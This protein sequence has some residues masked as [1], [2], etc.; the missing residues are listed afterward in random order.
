MPAENKVSILWQII[1]VLF[2]PIA[3]IWAFYRIKKLQKFFLYIVLPTIVLMLLI[4]I[5]IVYLSIDAQND[6]QKIDDLPQ[7][8]E[9]YSLM[10]I[11]GSFGS[12]GLTALEIYLILKWSEDWNKQFT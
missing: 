6:P 9:G 1:F 8:F 3:N 11:A 2:V 5:P 7:E 12:L 4:L 10:I